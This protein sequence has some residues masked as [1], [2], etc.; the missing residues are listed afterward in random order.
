[1]EDFTSEL[2]DDIIKSKLSI[3][4]SKR[5]PFRHFKDELYD[6]PEVQKEW[7]KFHEDEMKRIASEWLEAYNIN[8]EFVRKHLMEDK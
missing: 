4:L 1:M 5:K 8:A 6:F 3:A 2:P 7:Y